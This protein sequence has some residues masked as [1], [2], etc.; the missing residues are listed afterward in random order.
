MLAREYFH[1]GKLY[2]E[3]LEVLRCKIAGYWYCARFED[4]LSS[5]EQREYLI[6]DKIGKR[7]MT[8][9][10]KMIVLALSVSL[11]HFFQN[12]FLNSW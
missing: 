8:L 11:R 2:L 7:N 12:F 10:F 3:N 1:D 6:N 4:V 5:I 9:W